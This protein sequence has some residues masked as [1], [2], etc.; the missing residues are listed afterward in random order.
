M[1]HNSDFQQIASLLLRSAPTWEGCCTSG[2][3]V[4][5][6][7]LFGDLARGSCTLDLASGLHRLSITQG[8]DGSLLSRPSDGGR[9]WSKATTAEVGL[10]LTAL[11]SAVGEERGMH[12][13]ETA[14][15]EHNNMRELSRKA[16]PV[17][18]RTWL[19]CTAGRCLVAATFAFVVLALV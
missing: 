17:P 8:A 15:N 7:F 1:T 9:G 11:R 5:H 2:D 18:M 10:A 3:R 16:A 14:A 13:S 4:Y 6:A 12:V 19:R